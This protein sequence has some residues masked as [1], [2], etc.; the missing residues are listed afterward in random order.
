[1]PW[2]VRSTSTR[3]GFCERPGRA[4][5]SPTIRAVAVYDYTTG[6]DLRAGSFRDCQPGAQSK[7]IAQNGG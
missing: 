2:P 4:T 6:C 7:K 1:M 3:C 5:S